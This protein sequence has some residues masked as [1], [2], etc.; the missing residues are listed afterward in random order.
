MH[1]PEEHMSPTQKKTLTDALPNQYISNS[2]MFHDANSFFSA[3]SFSA[4][5]RLLLCLFK[6]S[7]LNFVFFLVNF[8][9]ESSAFPSHIFWGEAF[10]QHHEKQTYL[11]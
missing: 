6:E 3:D 4:V 8:S 7:F 9:K 5:C 2:E 10:C 1:E 11:S